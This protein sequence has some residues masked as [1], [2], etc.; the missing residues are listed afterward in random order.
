MSQLGLF[1]QKKF[2]PLFW[3]QF[4]GAFNDNLLKN[5][6]VIMVTF[7]SATVFGLPSS[8]IVALAGGIFILPFF[9][10]SAISG[11]LA[12]KF[13]KSKIT[14]WVKVFEVAIMIL[15][16]VGLVAK[17]FELL[18][19]CLFLAGLQS[20]IFGPIKYSILPQHLNHEEIVGGNALV[21]AGTFLAI[22]LG[23]IAG[24]VLIQ[25][26]SGPIVVS[27][28]LLI[29]AAIGYAASVFVPK[30][31]A[32]DPGLKLE[33]EPFGPTWKI[34][35][36]A[37]RTRSVYLSIL[38]IS[39]FWFFGA[40]L[41]S[42]FAPLCRDVFNSNENLVTVFL[43][44]F[45]LG[46]ALGSLLCEKLSRQHL[47]LGLVPLGSIGLTVSAIALSFHTSGYVQTSE[48][49]QSLDFI[50][51]QTGFL[52][53]LDLFLLSVFG[54]FFIVPMYT[55]MQERSEPQYRSRIIAANN[56]LNALFMVVSS[57]M[58]AAMF[59]FEVPISTAIL[60]LGILNA[61]V[62]IYI[63]T[64]LPEFLLRFLVWGLTRFLYRV[65]TFGHENIP[66]QG[67]AILI[68]NHLSFVDWMVIAAG[69]K[70]PVRFVM[71][72]SYFRGFL[73]KR[74]LVR[75]KVIPI[76]PAKENP[77][78]LEKAY[79]Q[80]AAEL[81]DGEIV[82]I[83]PEGKVTYDGKMNPFKPGILKM[84][85][86]TPVPVV[87]MGIHGLWGSRFSRQK[88]SERKLEPP[89]LWPLVTLRVGSVISPD[90]VTLERLEKVVEELRQ[91][92]S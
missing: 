39:W 13:E 17:V 57:I 51:S 36:F 15:A 64:L 8:Q 49:R 78:L 9:L 72:H 26:E 55:L 67:A 18:L 90:M 37:K 35:G 61:V 42:M 75:A 52:I 41:L 7:Q 58:L 66:K 46:T 28:A 50:S 29:V 10:F 73:I 16:A 1:T 68:A 4:F 74:I 85:A 32:V 60:I 30:A 77:E 84:L 45:S 40:A 70:R 79:A 63:Y 2:W 21:E 43:A 76:A 88:R 24:G 33:F 56:I 82:C 3:T 59:H 44:T 86:A 53:L 6:L 31:E 87:P 20:T 23:T 81:R 12:D 92:V 19:F 34:F 25:G 91:P 54:G 47:E 71:D 11:Q 27:A 14:R 22:L 5:A 80:M 83:F 62:A 38:G 48:V 69:I 89:T 65:R